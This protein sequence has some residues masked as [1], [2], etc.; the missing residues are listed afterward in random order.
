MEAAARTLVR[1]TRV[2]QPQSP[3]VA[4]RPVKKREMRARQTK[5]TGAELE[6][7][8]DWTEVVDIESVEE[9]DML[10][11]AAGFAGRRRKRSVTLEGVDTSSYGEKRPRRSPLD[12]EAQKDG[13]WSWWNPW[14]W[15]SMTS[16]PW[17]FA[18]TRLI[19][20]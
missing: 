1:S 12:E 20:L 10:S 4:P 6:D 3:R 11:L 16:R 15:P 14:I 17:G 5:A 19:Y 8:L 18:S 9:E 7:V 13:P 2:T